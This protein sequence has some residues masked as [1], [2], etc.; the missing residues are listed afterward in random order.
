[1]VFAFQVLGLAVCTTI[2]DSLFLLYECL[3]TYMYVHHMCAW[4]PQRTEESLIA[5]GTGVMDSCDC[6][7]GSGKAT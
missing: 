7:V 6:L 1:M 5:L 3:P 4:Y 2:P